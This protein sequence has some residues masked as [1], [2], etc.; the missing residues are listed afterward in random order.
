MSLSVLIAPEI[1]PIFVCDPW[2]SSMC[3]GFDRGSGRESFSIVYN[4]P[5]VRT[6]PYVISHRA[7]LLYLFLW[8]NISSLPAC[9]TRQI[10]LSQCLRAVAVVLAPC[11]Y[12]VQALTHLSLPDISSWLPVVIGGLLVLW[13]KCQPHTQ[14][15][16]KISSAPAAPN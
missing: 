1:P 7:K 16:N 11:C 9:L 4:S 13:S 12:P 2:W 15:A 5:L 3:V 10:R 14:A 6:A 8:F